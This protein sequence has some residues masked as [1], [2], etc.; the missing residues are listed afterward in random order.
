[1][2]TTEQMPNIPCQ[3]TP[4]GTA[5]RMGDTGETLSVDPQ[6]WS[7]LAR[8]P[9]SI[10]ASRPA[11]ALAAGRLDLRVMGLLPGSSLV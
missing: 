3:A 11:Q 8:T 6:R 7:Q 4:S 2:F 9:V 10:V 1:V 5:S